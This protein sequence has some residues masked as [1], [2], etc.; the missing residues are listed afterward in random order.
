MVKNAIVAAVFLLGGFALSSWWTTRGNHAMLPDVRGRVEQTGQVSPP[1][2]AVDLGAMR[3]LIRQELQQALAQGAAVAGNNRAADNGT[4]D[5]QGL[6]DGDPSAP[7][8]PRGRRAAP[9]P[10][11]LAAHAAAATLVDAGIAVGRW[12]EQDENQW[13]ELEDQLAPGAGQ[14]VRGRLFE[15]INEGRLVADPRFGRRA[16]MPQPVA[17]R[18]P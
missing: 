11:Q 3:T 18:A 1:P 6:A 4:S 14:D 17:V 2:S 15:A 8:V 16:G 5:D 9:T 12:T 10:A 7:V 13:Q